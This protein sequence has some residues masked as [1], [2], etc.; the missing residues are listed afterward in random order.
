VE[1]ETADFISEQLHQAK[2]DRDTL[3]KSD[4]YTK[5]EATP[6]HWFQIEH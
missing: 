5:Y 4:I 3:D 1:L 6:P 2:F